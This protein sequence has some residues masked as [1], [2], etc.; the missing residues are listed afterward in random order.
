LSH[1]TV[2][3]QPRYPSPVDVPGPEGRIEGLWADPGRGLPPAV[4]CHPHPA[5][6]GSMHSKVV[7]TLYRVLDAAGHPTLRFNFRGVGGSAGRYSG[8][9]GEI[10]DLDAAVEFARAR[11]GRRMIWVG[12]FSFG[13]WIALQWAARNPDV[14]RCI[15]VGVAV[16]EHAFD[17]LERAPAPLLIVQG[18]RDRYGSVD[19][20]RALAGRLSAAGDV[21][22][23]IVPGADHFFTGHL[24]GLAHALREGLGIASEPPE[25]T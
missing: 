18:D 16:D 23:R 8:W 14:E 11:T 25:G 15:A 6:R 22:L 20:V 7:H 24:R 13:A 1:E 2:N 3:A 12:G 19:A 4:L 17:F 10:G 21:A 9:N 5:H